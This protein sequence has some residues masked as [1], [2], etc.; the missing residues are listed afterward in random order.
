MRIPRVDA[1]VAVRRSFALAGRV[2][3]LGET[4]LIVVTAGVPR[5]RFPGPAYV[6]RRLE[7]TWRSLQDD[8]A[9]LSSDSVHAIA[10]RSDH[11]VQSS[12]TGQPRV[13]IHAVRS[14]VRAARA[15]HGLP[16]CARVFRGRGVRC[17]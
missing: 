1:G 16:R 14:L 12:S 2:R 10:L 17:V 3:S 9:R 6:A 15:E 11:F 4:R 7:R 8:L 13:V 5:G